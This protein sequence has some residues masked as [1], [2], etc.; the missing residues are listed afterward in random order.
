MSTI[1]QWL[2]TG[3]LCILT[4]VATV[5]LMRHRQRRQFKDF[6]QWK[7]GFDEWM[8]Q[9]LDAWLWVAELEMR[10]AFYLKEMP[11]EYTPVIVDAMRTLRAAP[12]SLMK[13]ARERG[14]VGPHEI[15]LKEEELVDEPLPP[16]DEALAREIEA[17][18]KDRWMPDGRIVQSRSNMRRVG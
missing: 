17:E 14:I 8:Q 2:L 3:G 6:A 13:A 15:R 4:M 10:G 12:R 7:L 18:K 1:V 16:S 11:S 5:I 9:M